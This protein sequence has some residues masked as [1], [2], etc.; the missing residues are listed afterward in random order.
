MKTTKYPGNG[1]GLIVEHHKNNREGPPSVLLICY[2]GS[3]SL[4]TTSKSMM[5]RLG[6]AKF[7]EPSKV[8]RAWCKEMMGE[9]PP[10]TPEVEPEDPNDNTKMI[11]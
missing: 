11:T 9:I 2:K 1:G 6:A 10:P 5:D 8:L 3:A 4:H 7:T